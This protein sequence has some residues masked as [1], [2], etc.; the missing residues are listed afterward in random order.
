MSSSACIFSITRLLCLFDDSNVK[1]FKKMLINRLGCDTERQLLC[2][3]VRLLS[4]TMT[5]ESLTMLKNDTIK[6]A[7]QQISK[8]NPKLSIYQ[9]IQLQ[10]RDQF[11]RLHSD[12]IDYFGTFLDK[13][14][15]IEFGYL[16]KQL[17]I[18]TQKQSYLLNR[19]NDDPV[20]IGNVASERFF[21]KET[22]PF[23]YSCPKDLVIC[24]APGVAGLYSSVWYQGIF[25]HLNSFRCHDIRYFST[26]PIEKFFS[27]QGSV[28][29][30]DIKIIEREVDYDLIC[31]KIECSAE[32]LALNAEHVMQFEEHFNNYSKD[33]CDSDIS[34][35]RNIEQ[36]IL[37]GESH[38]NSTLLFALGPLSRHIAIS[39]MD[40][41]IDDVSKFKKIFNTNVQSLEV[42]STATIIFSKKLK[43]K[44][45]EWEKNR[46]K[47]FNFNFK[48]L[49]FRLT[50]AGN[51]DNQ[52]SFLCLMRDIAELD[53]N[54]RRNITIFKIDL[55]RDNVMQNHRL[56]RIDDF[57][58]TP[59]FQLLDSL[60]NLDKNEE[61]EKIDDLN[62]KKDCKLIID[63]QDDGQFDN[64]GRILLYF[65]QNR[66]RILN[67][68]VNN[69]NEIE[70]RLSVADDYVDDEISPINQEGHELFNKPSFNLFDDQLDSSDFGINFEDCDLSSQD[71]GALYHTVIEWFQQIK[72]DY[73]Y[74][75]EDECEYRYELMKKRSI[76]LF[77]QQGNM[78]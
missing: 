27:N 45:E 22:N 16:N 70:I 46:K 53:I 38:T 63:M 5:N 8:T 41:E 68:I 77:L 19:S 31:Y 62:D 74:W 32:E 12:L 73:E 39:N 44:L 7:E 56:D 78:I 26:I 35:L 42:S 9:E 24:A 17:Y 18:E 52:R 51:T 25:S 76:N 64:F 15:S 71:L 48:Q 30:P 34:K 66:A 47:K 72:E 20:C 33:S 13:K 67:P 58:F 61:K 37:R 4:Q 3:V 75:D 28:P 55:M 60:F 57:S 54:W 14:Q 59:P 50:F 1:N 6:L 69:I 40:I 11:C 29:R 36:L 65:S 49:S 10:H 23:A 43:K 21:W 2:K